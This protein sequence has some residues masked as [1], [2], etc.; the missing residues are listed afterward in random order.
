MGSL[1]LRET[2]QITYNMEIPYSQKHSEKLA[3]K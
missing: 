1:E 3:L 2:S